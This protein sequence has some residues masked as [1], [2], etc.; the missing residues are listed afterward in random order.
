MKR[1]WLSALAVVS[2]VIVN[3]PLSVRA[4]SADSIRDFVHVADIVEANLRAAHSS[5]GQAVLNVASGRQTSV[6]VLLA[7]LKQIRPDMLPPEF[8]PPRPG[9]ILHSAGD[10]TETQCIL[11]FKPAV[12][13]EDGICQMLG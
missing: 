12:C 11:R 1:L 10:T 2:L 8:Q 3:A 5:I 6:L 4:Q 13:L 7:L 9:D